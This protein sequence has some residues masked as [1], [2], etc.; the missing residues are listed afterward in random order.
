MPIMHREFFKIISQKPE[1]VKG[2]CIYGN[3]P[4]YFAC[5]RWIL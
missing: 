3:S 1:Y 2:V 4:F 5:R